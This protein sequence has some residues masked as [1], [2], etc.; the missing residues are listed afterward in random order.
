MSCGAGVSP[1]SKPQARRTSIEPH[2][3]HG[4]LTFVGQRTRNELFCDSD[5]STRCLETFYE[6][7]NCTGHNFL[8][9]LVRHRG[10]T[11]S[12]H[13]F[14]NSHRGSG[15]RVGQFGATYDKCIAAP[16]PAA[17]VIAMPHDILIRFDPILFP[18][19]LNIHIFNNMSDA[20]AGLRH[21][22]RNHE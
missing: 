19:I 1:A 8:S 3:F 11:V 20:F 16:L 15:L 18:L 13:P 10:R 5:G 2:P 14:F 9:A 6:L 4:W 17:T 12:G 7:G 21:G 22:G